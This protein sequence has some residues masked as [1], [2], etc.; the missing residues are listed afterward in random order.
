MCEYLKKK[1]YVEN[2]EFF[3]VKL[4]Y[5]NNLAH[6]VNLKNLKQR[7]LKRK[8]YKLKFSKIIFMDLSV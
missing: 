4:C 1:T 2:K 6:N 7:N 3:F 8:K 5:E